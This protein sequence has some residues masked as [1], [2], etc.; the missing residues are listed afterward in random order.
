MTRLGDVGALAA[1]TPLSERLW[2]LESAHPDATRALVAG[3][4]LL[5]GGQPIEMRALAS[6]LGVERTSLF[7]W[8]G[9]RDQFVTEILWS[10]SIPILN[11]LDEETTSEGARRVGDV[12]GRYAATLIQ[13]SFFRTYLQRERERA[14][15][16]LTTRASVLQRRFVAVIEHLLVRERE[17]ET[18]E[19]SLPDAELAY[20]LA[21]IA[22]AFTYADLITGETPDATQARLAFAVVLGEPEPLDSIADPPQ[23]IP[24][25]RG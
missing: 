20:L 8:V 21:R 9:N 13:G 18:F 22:E 23:P 16:L 3:R 7:R 17:R 14:L 1:P 5:V 15:R 12:V 11:R 4:K 19:H 25:R 6:T 10:F 2:P 24:A